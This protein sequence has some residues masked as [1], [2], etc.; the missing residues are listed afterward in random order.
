MYYFL[1]KKKKKKK[2]KRN[3]Y[4]INIYIYKKTTTKKVK[5]Y[6]IN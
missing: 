3:I 4:E 6:I 2:K 1:K 5:Y